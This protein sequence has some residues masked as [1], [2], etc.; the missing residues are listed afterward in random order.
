MEKQNEG[1]CVCVRVG[2]FFSFAR[3]RRTHSDLRVLVI[4][5]SIFFRRLN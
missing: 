2:F 1:V 3:A 5:R 4:V